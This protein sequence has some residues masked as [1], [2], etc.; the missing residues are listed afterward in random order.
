MPPIVRAAVILMFAA[1]AFYSAGVWRAFFAGQLKASHVA[2]YWLGL[3]CDLSGTEL[4]RR[5]AGGLHWNLHTATGVGAL[6]LMLVHALWATE[7]LRRK[8]QPTLR[9]FPRISI[10]VWAIW[11]IPFITGLMLGSRRA[12]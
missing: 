12:L 8:Q 2:F 1:L 4:M 6:V 3:L 5:L 7:V 11:L 9:T 10:T